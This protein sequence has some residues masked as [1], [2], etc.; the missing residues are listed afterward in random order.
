M[1][2][3]N[4]DYKSYQIKHANASTLAEKQALNLELKQIYAALSEDDKLI[5]NKGLTAFLATETNRLGSDYEAIK[6]Q[7][8]GQVHDN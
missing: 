1:D 5:F 7:T 8:D 3:N 4:F 6:Y 2:I